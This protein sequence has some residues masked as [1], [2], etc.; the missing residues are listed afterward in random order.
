MAWT[1]SIRLI[2]R[3]HQRKTKVQNLIG[4]IV[5]SSK[6][7]LVRQLSGYH[8]STVASR[9]VALSN[10]GTSIEVLPLYVLDSKGTNAI[11]KKWRKSTR[12]QDCMGYNTH[13]ARLRALSLIEKGNLQVRFFLSL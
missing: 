2:C 12:H 6:L 5:G 11:P 8:K 7:L 3:R 9:L 4:P 1:K 13:I 10:I